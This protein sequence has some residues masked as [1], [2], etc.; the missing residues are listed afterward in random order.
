VD[1]VLAVVRA[2]QD[3][4]G[5]GVPAETVEAFDFSRVLR[6]RDEV[7]PDEPEGLARLR[8]TVLAQLGAL[9]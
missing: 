1:L 8:E 6:A 9:A 3:L 2:A 7:P 4:V 5:R